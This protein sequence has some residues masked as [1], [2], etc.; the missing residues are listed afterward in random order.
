MAEQLDMFAVMGATAGQQGKPATRDGRGPAGKVLD[1]PM[2]GRDGNIRMARVYLSQARHTR[3]QAANRGHRA[4]AATLLGWAAD[5]RGRA[6][7]V[8]GVPRPFPSK[9][10]EVAALARPDTG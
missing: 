2:Q 4:W 5:R 1:A 6:A 7:H 9:F 8:F 10:H 3:L